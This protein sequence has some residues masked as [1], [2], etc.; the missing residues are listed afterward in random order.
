MSRPVAESWPSIVAWLEQHLP[1]ALEHLQPSAALREISAL[2]AAMDRRLP[3]DLIAWLMLNNGFDR[4][5]AFG[6]LI[7]VLYTPMTI[8]RMLS[9]REMLRGIYSE[10]DRPAEAEPAGTGS[11]AWLDSFLPIGDAGTDSE[12][13]V[14]LRE[15][16]L[17][18]SVGTF[19]AEGGGFTG[20]RWFTVAEMLADVADALILNQPALQEHGHRYHAASG[21]PPR[22]WT[23][24]LDENYL[25]W[26][27]VNL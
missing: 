26:S 23:P 2:R 19:D 13:V 17:H 7:P 5:A 9:R 3:S 10:W 22:A 16:D 21:F 20:P 24:Y 12:L 25:H 14:D 18:G 8:E 11:L 27:L 6:S 4:L 1:H 15:G